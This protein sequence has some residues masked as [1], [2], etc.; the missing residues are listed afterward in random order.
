[1]Q[2]WINKFASVLDKLEC[3]WKMFSQP[4]YI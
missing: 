1:M 2:V 3:M 4:G